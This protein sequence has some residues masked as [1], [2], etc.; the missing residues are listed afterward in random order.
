MQLSEMTHLNYQMIPS[1]GY[2]SDGNTVVTRRKKMAN[3]AGNFYIG[4]PQSDD[5]GHTSY[6]FYVSFPETENLALDISHVRPM[7]YSTTEE[8]EKWIDDHAMRTLS[9]WMA[10]IDRQ[11]AANCYFRNSEILY[12]SHVDATL[13]EKMKLSKQNYME[14]RDKRG[15]EE[16]KK[17]I[18]QNKE[19][20][21]RR[22]A[23]EQQKI[24]AA[25]RKILTGGKINNDEIYFYAMSGGDYT[26]TIDRLFPYLCRR[27]S[28]SVPIRTLG[29]MNKVLVAADYQNGSCNRYYTNGKGG[30]SETAFTILNN[31]SA[32]IDGKTV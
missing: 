24:D 9:D 8:I 10:A 21:D 26:W 12:I 11:C 32:A 27:F 13:A 14:E 29:W 4:T 7:D 28:V 3:V 31:L 20:V 17:R 2:H 6:A 1:I 22:N 23:E 30:R 5:Y 18:A 25:I 15:E 19:F 16:R